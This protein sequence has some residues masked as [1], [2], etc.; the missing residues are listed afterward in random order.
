MK[1]KFLALI[2]VSL[3]L[4]SSF[5]M[6]F[7]VIAP[8]NLSTKLTAT[9]PKDRTDVM[10]TMWNMYIKDN[11]EFKYWTMYY[12]G[13]VNNVK[14]IGSNHIPAFKDV[15]ATTVLQI[16]IPSDATG[17]DLQMREIEIYK[18]NENHQT[19]YNRIVSL[20]AGGTSNLHNTSVD[21]S[22]TYYYNFDVYDQNGNLVKTGFDMEEILGTGNSTNPLLEYTNNTTSIQ[23]VILRSKGTSSNVTII[24]PDRYKGTSTI[25]SSNIPFTVE[26]GETFSVRYNSGDDIE[27][28]LDEVVQAGSL[29]TMNKDDSFY[30]YNDT[31]EI[32]TVTVTPKNSILSTYLVHSPL[33]STSTLPYLSIITKDPKVYVV[34]SKQAFRL[35][36]TGT[37]ALDI[38]VSN[39]ITN[40]APVV[41]TEDLN[42]TITYPMNNS[43]TTDKFTDLRFNVS[44]GRTIFGLQW[45]MKINGV[46]T[47]FNPVVD[48]SYTINGNTVY[49]TNFEILSNNSTI[50]K[51]DFNARFVKLPLKEG[52]N[53]IE[54]Y[55]K[56][57]NS[58][59]ST[60]AYDGVNI[61]RKEFVAGADGKDII[62][63]EEEDTREELSEFDN[64]SYIDYDKY[65]N[66]IEGRLQALGDAIFNTITAPFRFIADTL[67]KV[68]SWLAE[69]SSWIES[70]S[71]F[72]G[73]FLSFVPSEIMVA[74]TVLIYVFV[75]MAV[76]K[77]IR[78]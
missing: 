43:V 18:P 39:V 26:I 53:T 3:I 57:Y 78:G 23:S 9:H 58:S 48:G 74:I 41:S 16:S 24:R 64:V 12:P 14:V 11:N 36:N 44:I 60:R 73:A 4:T 67:E 69:S 40:S 70:I 51:F 33:P 27:L 15:G 71:K 68:V 72:F 42:V 62:T 25:S 21:Y 17:T 8:E 47:K 6:S 75:I 30:W 50:T 76:F 59:T 61:V 29:S 63:G 1:N 32:Q 65:D 49:Q 7:G 45:Y 34:E 10:N 20:T 35:T 19:I 55:A 38:D 54:I 2:L 31:G 56:N 77:L 46:E 52:Y 28:I 37:N 66:T 22:S 5:M 13:T